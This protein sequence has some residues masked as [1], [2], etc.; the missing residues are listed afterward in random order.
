MP[1]SGHILRI[2]GG[3]EFRGTV[4][5]PVQDGYKETNTVQKLCIVNKGGKTVKIESE[6]AKD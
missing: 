3:H 4:C 2:L 1:K 6:W 5:N